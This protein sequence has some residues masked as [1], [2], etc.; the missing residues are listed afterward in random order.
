[1]CPKTLKRG[2]MQSIKD[3]LEYKVYTTPDWPQQQPTPI[4]VWKG[5]RA[6]LS[7]ALGYVLIEDATW[8]QFVERGR[9]NAINLQ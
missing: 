8:E 1:M 5:V 4:M 6:P 9:N 3:E 7:R 2:M